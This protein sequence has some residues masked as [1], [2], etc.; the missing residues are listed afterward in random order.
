M[1]RMLGP[2]REARK[3]CGLSQRGSTTL[4]VLVDPT[5]PLAQSRVVALAVREGS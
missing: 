4:G 5:P 3:R 1:R 2:E